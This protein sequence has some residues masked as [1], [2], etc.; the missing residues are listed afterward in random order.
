M[1]TS[2][3][4][5]ASG[6]GALEAR[7]LSVRLAGEARPILAGLDLAAGPGPDRWRPGQVGVW[8]DD[9]AARD[10]R[11]R[12]VAASGRGSRRRSVSTATRCL[13]SIPVNDPVSSRPVSIA[14]MH[15]S[16]CR[17]SFRRSRR[18]GGST[19]LPRCSTRRCRASGSTKLVDRRVVELSTGQRQRVALVAT[20]AACPRP[21]L[22]DEPTAHLDDRGS[23]QLSDLLREGR[24][25]GGS[26]SSPNRRAGG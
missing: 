10:R 11:P 3:T 7:D 24:A 16:S 14:P 2:I 4:S 1:R 17:R 26:F 13:I 6:A 18:L 19:V 8:E 15:S 21:V 5:R 9:S 20:M 22:L 23:E 12:P 25:A